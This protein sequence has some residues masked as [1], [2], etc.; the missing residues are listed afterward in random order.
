MSNLSFLI[1]V[2]L[3]VSAAAVRAD[4]GAA[5][6]FFEK[7]VRP[8]LV[9][10]CLKCH[11]DAQAKGG[12]RLTGRE[13]LLAGGK[14]GPAVVPGEPAQ[15]LLIQAVEQRGLLKMPKGGKL[16][17][18][19]IDVLRRWVAAGAAWPATMPL[20]KQSSNAGDSYTAEQRAWWAFQPV[21]DP[22]PPRSKV[23]DSKRSLLTPGPSPRRGE[24]SANEI[25]VFLQVELDRAGIEP[26]AA[27]ERNVW[28]RRATFDLTGLPPTPDEVEA[29]RVDDSPEAYERVVD[30][31][32]ASPAY[33]E[34]W[35]RRWLDVVR[36]ADYYDANP[37]SRAASASCELTEAWRY[38]DWVVDALND[39][40]PFDQFIVHQIAGDLLPNPTGEEIYPAGLIASGFLVNGAWDRADA[41]KEKLVSDMVDDNLDTVG[42][43][44]LGLTLGCARCHDHKFDPISTEDYYALAG[45]FYS[46]HCL[47]T[48]GAKGDEYTLARVPL[49]PRAEAI[50]RDLPLARITA[51]DAKLKELDN[52]VPPVAADHPSRLALVK[53][54]AAHR[55]DLPPPYPTAMAMQE[56]GMPGG[57]FPNL[58]DV[59]VH[60]AGSY[61]DLGPTVPRRMPKFFAGA[62]QK[63]I[64]D[65]SGRMQLA[66]WI[67]SKQNPLTA[68]VIVNRVWQGHF[69]E[70][71]VRTPNNFGML[72]EKPLQPELL[73]WLAARFTA[74]GW[75]L[76]K[77]HRRI[78]TSAAYRR[79]SLARA[80]DLAKDPENRRWGRFNARRLEAEEMRD[81]LLFVADRLD[82]TAGGPA[83]S[84]PATPR[85][86]LYLQTCRWDRSGYAT[87][88]DA[89]NP[90]ASVEKRTTSIVAPQSLYLLNDRFVLDQA[91]HTADRMQR[92][93]PSPKL[94]TARI[95]QVYRVLFARQANAAEIE[96]AKK[97]L[98]AAGS[99]ADAAWRDFIHTLLCSNE[100]VYI[101]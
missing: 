19:E 2:V 38:R 24:G 54:I 32:L 61:N 17:A 50:R 60:I 28:L 43:V 1:P 83:A 89:A 15:S 51:L 9:S 64:T 37:K 81:A 47:E 31:L 41:D 88:F 73:D 90:D 65:G 30:R 40:L 12:L 79:S 21:K 75:S 13:S 16:T 78:M 71:L 4:D 29:F 18:T 48:L 82:R 76:K 35:A 20:A 62:S 85:R 55:R 101:E 56:W 58:Q 98:S 22:K 70:G 100:F 7:Q 52:L 77:L 63:K 49:V 97:F 34:R 6:E 74:D 39:D 59:R 68:R 57:L 25:D 8:L 10:K 36:Y 53:E 92:D 93:V 72:S 87:L 5:V 23:R 3:C 67:A 86:S 26:A 42:K 45:I 95:Q 91:E 84:D 44:F 99:D 27:A 66:E 46:S 33:G 14:S 96:V 11:D 80:D 69:G 94:Q